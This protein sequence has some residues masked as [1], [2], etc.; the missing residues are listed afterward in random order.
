MN[1]HGMSTSAVTVSGILRTSAQASLSTLS[2]NMNCVNYRP[3]NTFGTNTE[4][5][6]TLPV[7]IGAKLGV[8]LTITA[9]YNDAIHECS[10][11][12]AGSVSY[13]HPSIA[14]IENGFNVPTSGTA[15]VTLNG[16]N[17]GPK[18]F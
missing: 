9:N 17:F 15:M 16:F 2:F 7:G 5:Q 12:F 1:D 13:A 14:S 18:V 10:T 8:I 3:S 6:C 11:P 4:I